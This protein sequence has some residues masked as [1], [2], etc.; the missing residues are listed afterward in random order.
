MSAHQPINCFVA[1]LEAI[2][3]LQKCKENLYILGFSLHFCSSEGRNELDIKECVHLKKTL[4]RI[5]KAFRS[6]LCGFRNN[7]CQKAVVED[8]L[9][10]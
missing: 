9:I 4:K 2:Y 7:N 10:I 6:P 8:T 1:Q 5:F 3:W